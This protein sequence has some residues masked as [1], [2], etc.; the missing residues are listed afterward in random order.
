MPR[1]IENVCHEQSWGRTR[2]CPYVPALL[3][4][5]VVSKN[6]AR[7]TDTNSSGSEKELDE[8]HPDHPSLEGQ[9]GFRHWQSPGR[10]SLS[11]LHC[12]LRA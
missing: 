12:F 11:I 5:E 7:G 8:V 6:R 1:L 2:R 3:Q 4:E 10:A 9:F